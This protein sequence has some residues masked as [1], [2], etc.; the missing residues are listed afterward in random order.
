MNQQD[1]ISVAKKTSS[2][3]DGILSD[4]EIH[5]RAAAFAQRVYEQQ[6][7]ALRSQR[8]QLLAAWRAQEE[9]ARQMS[10]YEQSL[11]NYCGQQNTGATVQIDSETGSQTYPEQESAAGEE[12]NQCPDV[13]GGYGE[14]TELSAESVP[15][16]APVS[17]EYFTEENFS[18][19]IPS[20]EISFD[21][22]SGD[23]ND[24]LENSQEEDFQENSDV[25]P[26]KKQK[27]SIPLLLILLILLCVV[28]VIAVAYIMWAGDPRCEIY[29]DGILSLFDD[30]YAEKKQKSVPLTIRPRVPDDPRVERAE[31]PATDDVVTSEEPSVDSLS[32][33]END[34]AP[35]VVDDATSHSDEDLTES[36]E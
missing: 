26:P 29:R 30:E 32:E 21:D 11:E 23:G 31:P 25:A 9:Y 36:D 17:E 14:E 13:E 15:E 22:G 6:I 2:I 28:D 35:V 5:A 1:P 4:E 33:E 34:E 12:I 18:E 20:E 27:R 16:Q 3:P 24:A 10:A 7:V 19:E 8:D